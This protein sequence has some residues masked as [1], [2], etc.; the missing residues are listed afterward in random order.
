MPEKRKPTP[1]ETATSLFDE[2]PDSLKEHHSS[3]VSTFDGTIG[4]QG[5]EMVLDP[6]TGQPLRALLYNLDDGT[7]TR[8]EPLQRARWA[9]P[10]VD[11][12]LKE[13]DKKYQKL[14]AV[15]Q[16]A[17]RQHRSW[18]WE[19][20]RTTFREWSKARA[21]RDAFGHGLVI[22]PWEWREKKLLSPKKPKPIEVIQDELDQDALSLSQ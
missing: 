8:F 3:I 18:K 22:M 11:K 10:Q 2:L 14:D 6:R 12:D 1:I 4:N 19:K 17:Q 9:A 7:V 13:G 21:N 5:I 16:E 20:R 15:L